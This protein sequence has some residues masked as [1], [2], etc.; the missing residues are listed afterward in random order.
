MAWEPPLRRLQAARRQTVATAA[1]LRQRQIDWSPGVDRWSIGEVLDHLVLMEDY[2]RDLVERLIEKTVAQQKPLVTIT[3]AD[4]NP[5]PRPLPK[6]WLPKL[7]VPFAL[8]SSV[9]PHSAKAAFARYRMV[10]MQA[11]DIG[12]PR[13]CA[14]LGELADR[15]RRAGE[16][17]RSLFIS[18]PGLAYQRM[19]VRHPFSG[20]TNVEQLL[21][22]LTLHERRHHKQI[23]DILSSAGFPDAGAGERTAE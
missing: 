22:I 17:T 8:I 6:K 21:Q 1:T 5:A 15:L 14:P 18:E 19:L 12:L 20:R 10:R 2:F 13:S 11:P 23:N 7:E 3:F 4:F 16:E 9:T